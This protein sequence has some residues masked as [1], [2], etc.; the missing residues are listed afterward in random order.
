VLVALGGEVELL[1]ALDGRLRNLSLEYELAQEPRMIRV[2]CH[3]RW[4]APW[5]AA[6]S[7]FSLKKRRPLPVSAAHE[8]TWWATSVTLSA[9]KVL[10]D[11]RSTGSEP[12]QKSCLE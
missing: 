7:P 5:G 10:R 6:L 2:D 12:N 3:T 11:L 1:G 4:I 8:V 9:L